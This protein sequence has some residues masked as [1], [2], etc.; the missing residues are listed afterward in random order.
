M[1]EDEAKNLLVTALNITEKDIEK[2]EIFSSL[3][4]DFNIKYNLISKSTEK[5]Y[6][7]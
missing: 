7:V 4:L 6:L 1:S 2:L 3:L 5:T